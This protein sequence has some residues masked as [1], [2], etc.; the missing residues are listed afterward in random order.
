[1][2][3]EESATRA[4]VASERTRIALGRARDVVLAEYRSL[5][6]RQL[7]TRG[8]WVVALSGV[9]GIAVGA[10]SSVV[11]ASDSADAAS[12]ESQAAMTIPPIIAA[13]TGA[14]TT[15]ETVSTPLEPESITQ[16]DTSLPMGYTKVVSTGDPGEQIATY[17]VTTVDGV[18]VRRELLSA[19]VVKEPTHDVVSIGSLV[20]PT[21]PAVVPG[22]NRDIGKQIAEQWGWTG[23][24]WQCLDNLFE[25]E[26]NWRHLIANPSSGAYGIPQALPGSKMASVG[27]DWKTNPATQIT[28]GLGYIKGR[29][30]TPCGAWAAW[31]YRSPHWY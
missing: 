3:W 2:T 10:L 19:V 25:R 1:V 11:Y 7:G 26:S 31:T 8:A 27:S 20:V 28:W 21:R 16:T 9:A 22:S 24:E 5:A 12:T 13:D 18:E 29:Y 4:R 17:S 15:F 6:G 23:I 14:S 30:G